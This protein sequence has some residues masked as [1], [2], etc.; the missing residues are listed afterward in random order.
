M[1]LSEWKWKSRD[2]L[3]LYAR[4][5]TPEEQPKAVVCLIHGHGEHVTRY[6]HV[7]V[8]YAAAGYAMQGFDLRGHGQSEGP[9]GY[10]P[11]YEALLADINDFLADARQRYPGLP[12][13][14]HGH[15]MGGNQV[16]NYCLLNPNTGLRGAIVTSPWL[17][18]VSKP[19]PLL[20]FMV[21]VLNVVY[22]TYTQ[23]SGLD[24]NTISRD[25]AEVKKYATD[26]L[27]H[28]RITARLYT[29]MENHAL[30][31]LEHANELKVP[32]LL[33]HGTADGLSSYN[34]S[35][36]FAKK[37]G[38]ILTLRLWDGLYHETQNEPEKVEVIR[39]MTDWVAGRL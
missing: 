17:Q 13:F 24:Q 32:V 6:D 15:S 38:S 29:V 10:T 7:G 34:G 18:L 27:V 16:L 5:W 2:G 1:T 30:Y 4:S 37:A 25:P 36:E 33:M 39:T 31:A 22:P 14:L 8:A 21:K 35:K 11:S 23:A 20:S 9:R 19:N 28:D 26:P 12:V 3:Q